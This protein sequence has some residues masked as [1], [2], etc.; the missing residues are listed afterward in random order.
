MILL[1]VP[2]PSLAKARKISKALLA[3]GLIACANIVKSE[4]LYNWKGKRKE[5]VEFIIFA[6]TTQKRAKEAQKAVKSLHSYEIPCILAIKAGANDEYA[7]WV[8]S[9][10]SK[11]SVRAKQGLLQVGHL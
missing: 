7:R 10:T 8:G 4:S 1:Y 11:N 2:C 5:A 6:K 3:A 9:E